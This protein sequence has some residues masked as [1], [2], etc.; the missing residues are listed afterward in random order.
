MNNLK[1]IFAFV[2]VIIVFGSCKK[3]LDSYY[4]APDNLAAPIYEQLQSQGNFTKILSLIDKANYKGT[5]GA[6]G[7]WTL[8]APSDSAFSND[9][10]FKAFMTA[11][12]ISSVE[13]MDSATASSILQY[14]LVFNGFAQ[15]KI[16]D[17]QSSL[18]YVPNLA[19]KRRTAYYTGFYNDTTFSG[20]PVK[21]IASNRNG[22]YIL[23]DN[24][25]KYIPYFTSDFLAANGL[26]VTDYNYFYP[27]TPFSGFNVV[28]AKVTLKDIAAG[29]G[30]IHVIDHVITPLMSLDQYLRTK[31]EFSIFRSLFEQF[32]VSFNANVDATHRYQ[33]LTGSSDNVYVKTYNTLLAF[34]LNNENFFKLQENDAQKDGWSLVVPRNDVLLSYINSVLL[35]NYSSI[36]TLP[37]NVIADLLNA[38]MWQTSLWPSKFKTT[39][40]VLGESPH[41]DLAT[42]IID[43]KILSN[44]FFYGTNK[45]NEPNVFS[46]VY[47][48][49]YLN[50]RYSF[51]VNLLAGSDLR[52]SIINI[53]HK[54][55]MFMIPD[56]VFRAA[57]YD[58]NSSNNTFIFTGSGATDFRNDLVR[59]L[60]TLVVETPNGELDLLGTPGF[61]GTGVAATYGGEV[62]KYVGNTILTAGTIERT[63]TVKI[64]SV[65]TA[66]NGRLLYINNLLFFPLQSV[67]T[68]LNTLGS[69][70]SSEYSMFWNYLKNSTAYDPSVLGST[71][72]SIVGIGGGIFYTVFAPN[73]NAIKQAI[74]AGLLPGTP[75]VPNYTPTLATD[76]AL[77]EK[78][79]FYHVVDKKTLIPDKKDVG[80]YPMLLKLSNGDPTTINI[81]YPGGVFEITDA[82][83]RKAHLV[84]GANNQTS[85]NNL[86]NRTVIHLLDN[87]LK[88]P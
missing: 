87:Y 51:M 34:S 3:K 71:L 10:D 85:S 21:A 53:G 62:I 58:Y 49:A 11:K 20:Q 43:K 66:A 80:T 59:I 38:H 36:N 31:P 28:N 27:S 4:K 52:N 57:G 42:N 74:S 1:R 47:G 61:A 44:G 25:N 78:F 45:V 32:M 26:A 14:L 86:S 24:N 19:Y 17:Y 22:S 81:Q 50:P 2:I 30:V 37:T 23:A 72:P 65:K 18:G 56:A 60:N 5:L 83:G 9:T 69:A 39:N 33:V 79:M 88:Y 8:F 73:N 41:I 54:Y 63:I 13:N 12:G 48:K 55:T 64:D 15:D 6:A 76:K 75:T 84:N 82:A 29:N 68:V 7:Y 40:N 16:D 46:S 67:G 35:E 70:T 77:V